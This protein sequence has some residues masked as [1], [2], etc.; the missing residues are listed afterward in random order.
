M[1]KLSTQNSSEIREAVEDGKKRMAKL[2]AAG[3]ALP[4]AA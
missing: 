1:R 3:D 4:V 2:I